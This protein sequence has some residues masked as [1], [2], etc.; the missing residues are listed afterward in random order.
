[1]MQ[2]WHP[3]PMSVEDLRERQAYLRE[4]C[5]RI[6]RPDVPATR[7]SFRVNFPD[8]TGRMERAPTSATERPIGQ[9]TPAPVAEDIRR[10]RHGAGLEA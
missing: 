2:L 6:G 7:M 5:A 8:I 3:A 10:F 1:M 4:A 9:G